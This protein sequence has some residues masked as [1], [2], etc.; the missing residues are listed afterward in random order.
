MSRYIIH[1]ILILKF[2]VCGIMKIKTEIESIIILLLTC[3]RYP[4]MECAW[5]RF[6]HFNRKNSMNYKVNQ[7]III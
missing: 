2:Q 3:A 1:S 4:F 6:E 5:E 7:N